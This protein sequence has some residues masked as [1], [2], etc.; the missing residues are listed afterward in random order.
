MSHLC[1]EHLST[2][3]SRSSARLRLRLLEID[4]RLI[5][6]RSKQ[7]CTTITVRIRRAGSRFASSIRWHSLKAKE[8]NFHKFSQ[9]KGEK[10]HVKNF[11]HMFVSRVIFFG[12]SFISREC[13]KI[14][15][16]RKLS[17]LEMT[18]TANRRKRSLC[19]KDGRSVWVV[20]QVS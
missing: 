19:Q 8:L 1:E 20:L 11:A 4:I 10:I 18:A 17:A 3:D 12:A 6:N 2:A 9:S 13:P 15:I 14:P 7:T 16:S 5:V